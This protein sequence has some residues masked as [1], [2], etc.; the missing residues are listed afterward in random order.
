MTIE[1]RKSIVWKETTTKLVLS[2]A[3]FLNRKLVSGKILQSVL[4]N[5]AYVLKITKIRF[6]RDG[7][8]IKRINKTS[9]LF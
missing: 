5:Q 2:S 8:F 7:P 6:F 4:V 9:V 3:V 1:V